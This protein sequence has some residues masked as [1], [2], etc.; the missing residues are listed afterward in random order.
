[1]IPD[2]FIDFIMRV[3]AKPITDNDVLFDALEAFDPE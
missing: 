2:L 3:L 1:M